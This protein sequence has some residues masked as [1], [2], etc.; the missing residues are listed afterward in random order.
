MRTVIRR[1]AALVAVLLLL[2]PCAVGSAQTTPEKYDWHKGRVYLFSMR[3]AW[4][5]TPQGNAS[6]DVEYSDKSENTYVDRAGVPW[7]LQSPCTSAYHQSSGTLVSLAACTIGFRADN[8]KFTAKDSLGGS[9]EAIL[10]PDHHNGTPTY[11]KANWLTDSTTVGTYNYFD[12]TPGCLV[13]QYGHWLMDV[14]PHD[15]SYASA[16][17]WL[18]PTD[19]LLDWYTYRERFESQVRPILSGKVQIARGDGRVY[20]VTASTPT[21]RPSSESRSTRTSPASSS[22]RRRT[23]ACL[24]P[25]SPLISGTDPSSLR[26]SFHFYEI[27]TNP[28][29]PTGRYLMEGALTGDSLALKQTH[30]VHQPPG[31][32]MV[33]ISATITSTDL[34]GTIS[35][36]GCGDIT[37]KKQ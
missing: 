35:S 8:K 26:A 1:I 7:R 17:T 14:R 13:C 29:V 3:P 19:P 34:T 18:D 10:M 28:G 36:P 20:R 15:G 12:P 16:S 5:L 25:W 27:L 23:W 11:Q 2:S 4:P 32:D 6:P 33:D 22:A 24:S 9:F 21:A 30:W 37:L 31:Y